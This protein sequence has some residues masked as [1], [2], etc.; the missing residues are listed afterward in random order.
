MPKKNS[1]VCKEYESKRAFFSSYFFVFCAIRL[2][3]FTTPEVFIVV[4]PY[5]DDGRD[6]HPFV[7][8]KGNELTFLI[9]YPQILK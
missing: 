7:N 8:I 2:C 1:N 6:L 4:L 5:Y 9:Y 3:S